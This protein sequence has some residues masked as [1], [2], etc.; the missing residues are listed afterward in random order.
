MHNTRQITKAMEVVSA[1]KMRRSQGLALNI[2]PFAVHAFE[3]LTRILIDP[4]TPLPRLMKPIEQEK[5]VALIVVTSDKGLAG[6][7]NANILR[8]AESWIR[9][10][11]EDK[12]IAV[13]TVG[14]KAK[15]YFSKRSYNVIQDYIGTGDYGVFDEVGHIAEFLMAQFLHNAYDTVYGIY[16]HFQST[17]RQQALVRRLLPI[18]P[19]SMRD[20]IEGIISE[21]SH[22][23]GRQERPVPDATEYVFEPSAEAVLSALLP[24]VFQLA[25]YHIIL[26]SN[27]SEHSARML[28]MKKA[29][30]NAKDIID[31]LSLLYNKSRQAAI[32]QE[33]IEITS[34]ITP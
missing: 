3:I 33:L 4:A 6:S 32:T 17:L 25:I 28:A 34:A 7:F 29:S 9:E 21:T 10:N 13:I 18:T 2:R 5:N 11:G 27:A 22:L 8:K 1:T 19:Q 12:S 23:Q 31:D 15:E 26:E 30:D 20:V 16:T 24:Y 14:K